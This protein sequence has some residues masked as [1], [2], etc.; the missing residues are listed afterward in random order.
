MTEIKSAR[1]EIRLTPT[2]KA[3][4]EANAR[5][6]RVSVSELIVRASAQK[7]KK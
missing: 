7:P 5:K 3:T 4:L 2:E 1:L 6:E